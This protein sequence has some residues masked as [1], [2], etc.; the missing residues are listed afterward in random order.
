MRPITPTQ[1]ECLIAATIEPLQFY[2][3]GFGHSKAGPFYTA[4]TVHALLKTGS[5]RFLRHGP[6]VMVTARAA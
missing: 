1:R 5:L 6:Q 4:Q 3:R 2:R